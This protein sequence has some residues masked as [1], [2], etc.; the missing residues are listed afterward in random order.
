MHG[1]ESVSHNL[2]VFGQNVEIPTI[3][4]FDATL[5]WNVG[6]QNV[7][8]YLLELLSLFIL[9]SDNQLLNM[10]EQN[11]KIQMFISI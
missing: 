11:F 9:C 10:P 7:L 1:P 4:A 2:V 3:Q 6:L 5:E 8:Y